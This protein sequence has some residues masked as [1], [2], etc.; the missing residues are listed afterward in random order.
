M[1]VGYIDND[2]AETSADAVLALLGYLR[3]TISTC[4]GDVGCV[5]SNGQVCGFLIR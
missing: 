4:W 2:Q 1:G 3:I 5:G